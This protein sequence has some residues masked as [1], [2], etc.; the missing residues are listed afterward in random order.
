MGVV[1]LSL[2]YNSHCFSD[3]ADQE[4]KEQAVDQSGVEESAPAE[5]VISGVHY[6]IPEFHGALCRR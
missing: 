1:S 2:G 4:E 5:K 3:M 6:L